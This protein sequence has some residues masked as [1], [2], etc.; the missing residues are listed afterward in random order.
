MRCRWTHMAPL[1][2]A[3]YF[4]TAP[5]M[6]QLLEVT[7]GIGES[8]QNTVTHVVYEPVLHGHMLIT[9]NVVVGCG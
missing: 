3:T 9:F 1:H 6:T 8:P 7:K 2:Y 5:A 4:D